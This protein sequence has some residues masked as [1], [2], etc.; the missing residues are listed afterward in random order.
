MPLKQEDVTIETSEDLIDLEP[1][2]TREYLMIMYPMQARMLEHLEEINGF[3][4]DALGRFNRLEGSFAV[5][6]VI[7]AG[8]LLG[9]ALK[10]VFGG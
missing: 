6:G 10:V 8:A 5:A 1:K 2:T 3:K 7:V 9:L 4:E